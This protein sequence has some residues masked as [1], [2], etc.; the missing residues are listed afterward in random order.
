MKE[1]KFLLK[2]YSQAQVAEML[3]YKNRSSLTHILNNQRVPAHKVGALQKEYKRC[4][5]S[6]KVK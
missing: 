2:F 4:L 5:K 1:L 6:Q 3:G